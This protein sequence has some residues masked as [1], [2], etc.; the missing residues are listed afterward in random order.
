MK[1]IVPRLVEGIRDQFPEQEI[2]CWE[3]APDEPLPQE[4][5]EC[6]F[7]VPTYMTG[8]NAISISQK[9]PNLKVV[10]LTTAGVDGVRQLV[11]DD[12]TL[13]N[14]KGVHDAATSEIAVALALMSRRSLHQ[15]IIAQHEGVWNSFQTPGLADSK[16]LIVG[17][18]SIGGAI[19]RRLLPFEVEIKRVARTAKTGVH[20]FSDL[21]ELLP[22]AD[23]VI[24]IVPLTA[25]TT[26]L[27]DAKMLSRMKDGAT[28]VNVARGAVVDTESLANELE[29]GRINAALD[30][31]HPEPLPHGHRLWTMD[32]CIITP[33]VGGYTNAFGKRVTNLVAE[34]LNRFMNN[35]EL[36]NVIT[37]E[38]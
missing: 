2:I 13:C 37:A 26:G 32:N 12:V 10:Q 21:P 11:G 23:V 3:H 38:Y 33:H 9:M 34:N 17:Y 1:V 8:A 36:L 7:Y 25:E 30:V 14:A 5:M 18:G 35:E 27:F 22:H 29:T 16:I 20:A 15:N 31:T 24:L 28:L 4:A 6:E 19:E